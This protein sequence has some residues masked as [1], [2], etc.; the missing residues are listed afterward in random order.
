MTK[1]ELMRKAIE[2][3]VKNV[4]EGGGPFGA[5]IAKNG[6][7]EESLQRACAVDF[8]CFVDRIFN[9]LHTGE[10]ED[11]VVSGPSP[12]QGDDD[13]RTGCPRIGEPHDRVH[14][15]AAENGVD[16]TVICKQGTEDH[17]VRYER[18]CA[19]QENAGTEQ[20]LKTQIFVVQHG[21]KH[22]AE[23]QHDRHLNNQ[24]KEGVA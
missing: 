3:S 6:D 20:S 13:N 23:D 2:L 4:A 7:L 5:V 14:A 9:V 1:E 17:R 12:D 21:S 24:I 11:H 8:G 15:E 16:K 22:Q 18:C 19:R 10:I